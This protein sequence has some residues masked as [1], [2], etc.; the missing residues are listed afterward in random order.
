LENVSPTSIVAVP[1]FNKLLVHCDTALFSYPLDLVIRVS[2]RHDTPETLEGSMERL[3]QKD[4]SVLFFKAGR[5][6]HRTLIVYATKTFMHVTLHVLELADQDENARPSADRGSSFRSFGSPMPIPRDAHDAIFL[7]KD[8]AICASKAIHI[9]R[10]LNMNVSPIVVPKLFDS[11]NGANTFIHVLREKCD[12]AKIL[13]LVRCEKAEFLLVYD[14]FGCYMDSHGK[15]ARSAGYISWE[16]KA[17]AYAHRGPHLL[18]F[19][20]RFIEVRGLASGKL[21]QVIE[22]KDVRL[23]HSGLTKEDMLVAAM[24]GDIEDENG[25]SEKVQ[26]LVQTTAIDAQELM[27]RVEQQWD[28]WDV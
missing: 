22:G 12:A 24:T 14:D 27:G 17:T 11:T 1:E 6:A 19:S 20:P 16:C 8:V 4:G 10:P 7:C 9:V 5:V 13:G 2:Q 21:V 23:V 26:E 15:P 28:E 25:L 3:A 18:L